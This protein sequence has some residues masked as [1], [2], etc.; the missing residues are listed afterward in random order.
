MPTTT[1]TDPHRRN[2]G[3][4]WTPEPLADF[5]VSLLKPDSHQTLLDPALGTGVFIAKYLEISR[6]AHHVVNRDN[7]YGCEIDG[8]IYDIFRSLGPG[9][10]SDFKN[11]TNSD[12]LLK[13]Y[14][15]KFDAIIC[16]PPYTRHHRLNPIYKT[17]VRKKLEEHFNISLSSFSSQFVY[18]FLKSL[19]ELSPTGRLVYLTPIELYEA[20]YA[21]PIVNVL[22]NNFHPRAVFRFSPKLNIFS[23]ADNNLAVT[24]V[25]GPNSPDTSFKELEISNIETLHSTSFHYLSSLKNESQFVISSKFRSQE[26]K[27]GW[28]PLSKFAHVT[29]GIATGRND[30]FLFS[31]EKIKATKIPTK[32]F[33]S[34]ITRTKSTH[35]LVLEDQDIQAQKNPWL[36]YIQPETSL[37]NEH[38]KN[39]LKFGEETRVSEGYL[40]KTRK[41]WYHMERRDPAPILFTYLGRANPRFIWNKSQA[42]ALSTFLLLYPCRS[43][44]REEN[45]GHAATDLVVSGSSN[46]QVNFKAFIALLNSPEFLAE[47]KS[48]S[49][50]YGSGGF[51]IEPRELESCLIPDF[52]KLSLKDKQQLGQEFDDLSH[53]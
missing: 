1:V 29:R 4:Y 14:P 5:L 27:K 6:R 43:D 10:Q 50:T 53:S 19:S 49:R 34:V 16:N 52:S 15:Q 22:Q 12:Y 24:V 8:A 42:Q 28:V 13:S 31:D 44:F 46:D 40:V 21:R 9:S 3:Q 39:Y 25:D 51:K 33:Q 38:L 48:R 36:L 32:Y 37:Q 45:A 35:G 7:I 47:L 20:A 30:Y 41:K 17:D 18:F 23:G 11:V 2:L 26:D